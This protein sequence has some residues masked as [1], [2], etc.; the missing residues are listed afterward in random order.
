MVASV[1]FQGRVQRGVHAKIGVGGCIVLGAIVCIGEMHH[2]QQCVLLI[3]SKELSS[4]SKT[5]FIQFDCFV[6]TLLSMVNARQQIACLCRSIV[7]FA[8]PLLGFFIV[9]L[10]PRKCLFEIA[11]GNQQL[12]THMFQAVANGIFCG[13]F[14]QR[15]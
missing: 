8:V 13:F 12:T 5:F 9:F 7:G 6:K 4:D 2:P 3:F 14:D 11:L 15:Q 10:G 1:T